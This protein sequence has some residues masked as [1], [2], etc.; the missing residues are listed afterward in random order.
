MEAT[1]LMIE[2]NFQS[3]SEVAKQFDIIS[4]QLKRMATQ[5][6]FYDDATV[7]KISFKDLVT[8]KCNFRSAVWEEDVGSITV[9]NIEPIFFLNIVYIVLM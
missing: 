1:K 5:C 4:E 8:I 3:K 6:R 2:R 7:W 9:S